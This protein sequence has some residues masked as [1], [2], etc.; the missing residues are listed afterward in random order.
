MVVEAQDDV[1]NVLFVA[2]TTARTEE[3]GGSGPWE[4]NFALDY[5]GR[6]SIV[7]YSPSP[8]DGSRMAETRLD[9]Y[10]GDPQTLDEFV[11]VTYPLPNT[12]V[13]GA[14]TVLSAA[15]YAGGIDP[16]SLRIV[17]M[18]ANSRIILSLPAAG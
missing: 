11:V 10:F 7:A 2:P 9:V 13:T 16:D 18:D 3:V 4:L 14:S 8:V 6:G 1:G 15:G 17:V 12:I 5:V